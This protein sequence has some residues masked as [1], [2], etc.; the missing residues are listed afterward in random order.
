MVGIAGGI[1]NPDKVEDHV[2]LG[3]VVVSNDG[4]VVQYDLDKATSTEITHR[5]SPR[6]PSAFLLEGVRHLNASALEG[7]RPWERFSKD[8]SLV[9]KPR[10]VRP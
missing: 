1:P 4:G 5:H 3:D 2:R 6:P 10:I 7:K 8:A 9:F